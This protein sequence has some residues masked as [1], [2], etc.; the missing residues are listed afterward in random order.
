MAAGTRAIPL[1]LVTFAILSPLNTPLYIHSY[2]GKED[3]FRYVQIAH[4]ALDMV[5]EKGE[6]FASLQVPKVA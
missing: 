4:S 1:H 6:C 3:E 5:E 2:T